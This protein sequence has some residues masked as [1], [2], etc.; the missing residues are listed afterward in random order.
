MAWAYWSGK[1]NDFDFVLDTY[2]NAAVAYSVRKLREAYTGPCVEVRRSTDNATQDIGFVNNYIDES[3]LSSF[4]GSA[5]LFISKIYD[6]TGN[7]S[8]ATRIGSDPADFEPRIL[9]SGVIDKVNGKASFHFKNASRMEFS[10]IT[11]ISFFVVYKREEARGIEYM[12]GATGGNGIFSGGSS[13]GVT[14]FGYA[15]AN[16]IRVQNTTENFN[17]NQS[18]YIGD[19]LKKVWSNGTDEATASSTSYSEVALDTLGRRDQTATTFWGWHQEIILYTSNKSSDR[20]GIEA[21]QMNYFG[22]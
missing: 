16:S 18:T 8:H 3:A 22:I 4:G 1:K 6:Q 14:G 17:Q 11:P 13:G 5:S 2:G 21:N 7:G 10:S 20:T 15:S 19:T 12:V 9:T